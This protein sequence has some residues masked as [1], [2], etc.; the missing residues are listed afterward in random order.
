MQKS[1][2]LIV[3]GVIVVMT[4]VVCAFFSPGGK[5]QSFAAKNE[6]KLKGEEHITYQDGLYGIDFFDAEIGWTVGSWGAIFHTEDGGKSWSRQD[7]NTDKY[8]Y[9]VNFVNRLNGW[10]VGNYGII[11]HTQDGGETW[12]PQQSGTQKHLFKVKFLNE[13]EGWAIG[14]WGAVLYTQDGGKNW[15]DK[16]IKE[17]IA[18]ASIALVGQHCWVVGEFGT[19]FH[20]DNK[21]ENW[22]KQLS[23]VGENIFLYGV[24]FATLAEGWAVGLGGTVLRTQDGGKTWQKLSHE[25]NF[26]NTLFDAVIRDNSLIAVGERGAIIEIIETSGESSLYQFRKIIPDPITYS[27]LSCLSLAGQSLWVV[28]RNGTILRLGD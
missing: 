25:N 6:G 23:G 16:S 26:S 15:L 1:R 27:S 13:Y 10:I 14:Y 21:G 18:F 24:D 22:E 20:T 3:V 4:G 17:D 19:I 7:S 5:S 28:G 11:L 9:S 12:E 2:S 8:L